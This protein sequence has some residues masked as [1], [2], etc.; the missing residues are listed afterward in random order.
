L[1]GKCGSTYGGWR[2]SHNLFRPGP[3]SPEQASQLSYASLTTAPVFDPG[4]SYRISPPSPAD[5]PA[6]K[7]I[8]EGTP[9]WI[10]GLTDR[11]QGSEIA[12]VHRNQL[13]AEMFPSPN[14]AGG[15]E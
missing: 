1:F 8:H 9:S 2:F 13:L 14:A 5:Q 4:F 12:E 3:A 15:C 7:D 10:A 11:F 6:I